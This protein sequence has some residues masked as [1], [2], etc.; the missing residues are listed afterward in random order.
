MIGIDCFGG[1]SNEL[2]MGYIGNCG[3]GVLIRKFNAGVSYP[4]AI[5]IRRMKISDCP[6]AAIDFYDGANL[7]VQ[8]CDIEY[9]GTVGNDATGGM[10]VRSSVGDESEVGTLTI[11]N[12][13]FE[14]SKSW[15]IKVEDLGNKAFHVLITGNF[16][17]ASNGGKAIKAL[18]GGNFVMIANVA[19]GPGDTFNINADRLTMIGCIVGTLIDGSIHSSVVMNSVIGSAVVEGSFQRDVQIGGGKSLRLSWANNTGQYMVAPNTISGDLEF[20]LSEA[21][22][23][24]FKFSGPIKIGNNQIIGPRQSAIADLTAP[25]TAADFNNLLAS[26]RAHGLIGS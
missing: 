10:I 3:T 26:L 11:C 2:E 1:N 15:A 22:S 23:G 17:A 4:N 19:G 7:I 20:T 8:E 9:N 25:P 6:T 16:I 13:W 14:Q 24:N 5:S 21:G 18:G 12:S